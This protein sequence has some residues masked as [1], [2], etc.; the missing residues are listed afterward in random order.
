MWSKEVF[1]LVC[2]LFHNYL[3][4]QHG[5]VPPPI[6][7]FAFF[8]TFKQNPNHQLLLPKLT[9]HF[10]SLHHCNSSATDL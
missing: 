9:H 10:H 7:P 4:K 6:P 1:G 3:L 2:G 5:P 8:L